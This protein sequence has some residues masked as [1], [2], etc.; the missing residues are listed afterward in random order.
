MSVL[1][2]AVFLPHGLRAKVRTDARPLARRGE[3]EIDT[4]PI[5]IYR[6]VRFSG[7]KEMAAVL[8]SLPFFAAL[9]KKIRWHFFAPIK[10]IVGDCG[11]LLYIII[12]IADRGGKS[13]KIS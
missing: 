1:S 4:Q 13:Q 6:K 10:V 5:T 2:F 3:F 11:S 9:F 12:Y 8:S 7:L